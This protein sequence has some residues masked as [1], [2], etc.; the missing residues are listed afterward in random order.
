MS[1]TVAIAGRPPAVHS[2]TSPPLPPLPPQPPKLTRASF[3]EQSRF[4]YR[5]RAARSTNRFENIYEEGAGD[6][7]EEQQDDH[8]SPP[9]MI[10]TKSEGNVN[11][12]PAATRRR[13]YYA[14]RQ[15]HKPGVYRTWEEAEAQFKGHPDPR[16]QTF[17]SPISA[18]E[19]VSGKS[20]FG[21]RKWQQGSAD[22]VPDPFFQDATA[23]ASMMAASGSSSSSSSTMPLQERLSRDFNPT[24]RASDPSV[25]LP[26]LAV[27]ASR[28]GASSSSSPSSSSSSSLSP[29]SHAHASEVKRS[30][31]LRQSVISADENTDAIVASDRPF[32]ARRSSLFARFSL[33][34][35]PPPPAP[36][37]A[38][39]KPANAASSRS[40]G[41]RQRSRA[42]LRSSP[43]TEALPK[44]LWGNVYMEDPADVVSAEA[45]EP[46]L[47]SAPKF[48]RSAMKRSNVILPVSAA[49]AMTSVSPS[50]ER[51][52]PGSNLGSP[53]LSP[54]PSRHSLRPDA[55]TSIAPHS[56]H[57]RL[58][59]LADAALDDVAAL[60]EPPRLGSRSRS[61]SCASSAGPPTPPLLPIVSR[62]SMTSLG[63][64]HSGYMTAASS[65]VGTHAHSESCTDV[66][67]AKSATKR[68]SGLGG[69]LLRA[70]KLTSGTSEDEKYMQTLATRRGSS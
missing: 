45:F 18:Q 38:D 7:E 56:L 65:D 54:K 15:G 63:E 60:E 2:M 35:T 49:A 1:A 40:L 42:S 9:P 68:K 12:K 26:P 16:W 70:L 21:D 59:A 33:K 69:R 31:P 20:C 46:E 10:R 43:S 39:T 53:M 11:S 55:K 64:A 4:T 32:V 30:S 23:D 5:S 8:V 24:P 36:P 58:S 57:D 28:P 27:E 22:A 47:F 3:S 25:L 51:S 19:Y 41:T 62:D 6:T 67:H 14:V 50:P 17:R 61:S 52:R 44:G 34:A 48:S 37:P 66:K 29:S 13:I